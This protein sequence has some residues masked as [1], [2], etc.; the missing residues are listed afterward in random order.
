VG[1]LA[2]WKTSG[3]KDLSDAGVQDAQTEQWKEFLADMTIQKL[4]DSGTTQGGIWSLPVCQVTDYEARQ[5]PEYLVGQ[6]SWVPCHCQLSDG[7]DAT[8]E[9]KVRCAVYLDI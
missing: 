1:S 6:S 4:T 8:N 2:Y 7:S 3:L 9:F 5:Y